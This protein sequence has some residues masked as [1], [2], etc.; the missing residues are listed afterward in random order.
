MTP[1]RYSVLTI[2]IVG[3]FLQGCT[4]GKVHDALTG[5]PIHSVLVELV[6]GDCTGTGCKGTS[7]KALTDGFG[8][9]SFGSYDIASLQLITPSVGQ[10]ALELRVSKFGY[11]SVT[12]FHRP[13]Y[14]QFTFIDKTYLKSFVGKVYLCIDPSLDS[15][16][17]SICDEAELRY[18][19]NPNDPDSDGDSLSDA[20]EIYGYDGVDLAYFGANPLRKDVFIEI[21][22][23]PSLG[24]ETEAIKM[25]VDAFAAAPVANQDGSTGINLT[26][27]VSDEIE[28][29]DADPDLNPV[30]AEFD[31]IKAKYFPVRRASIFHYGLFANQI[32]G[33]RYSGVS[34]GLPASDF[35][36][37]LGS[38]WYVPGGW[39]MARAGTLMHEIGHNLGLHHG[40]YND[41]WNLKPNYLSVM[42]YYYQVFGLTVD[43]RDGI[44]DYSRLHIDTLDE[45]N[46]NERLAFAP[47]P[48]TGTTEAEL[49]RYSVLIVGGG[50]LSGNASELLDFNRNETI[51]ES[52]S[53]DLDGDSRVSSLI[54]A[55]NNDWD[56]IVFHGGGVIGDTHLVEMSQINLSAFTLPEQIEACMPR[57]DYALR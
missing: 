29:T 42:N 39:M 32:G 13:N 53:A 9:F 45:T 4:S 36:V 28:N 34:R 24:P 1:S 23:Y 3:N 57:L 19:T 52:T 18:G 10:E 12:I 25:V 51:E 46:L 26:L 5:A 50:F 20:A 15:D 56:Q 41:A 35:I 6:V 16:S 43:G 14:Q 21:D 22:Y 48:G 2:L 55:S 49:A 38:A 11:E 40:G 37:S 44:L 33:D 47:V 17:D 30:F 54:P 31:I 7:A 27:D 8:V